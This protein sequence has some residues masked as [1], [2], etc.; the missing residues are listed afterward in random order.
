MELR[1]RQYKEVFRHLRAICCPYS[2]R[3]EGECE[4]IDEGE[5]EADCDEAKVSDKGRPWAMTRT[6]RS[7]EHYCLI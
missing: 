1:C 3:K 6:Y 2:A 4:S 7:A 5:G